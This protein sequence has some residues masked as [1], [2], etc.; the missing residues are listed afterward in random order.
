MFSEQQVEF[1]KQQ[2]QLSC[3]SNSSRSSRKNFTAKISTKFEKEWSVNV[4]TE[5]RTLSS[6]SQVRNKNSVKR[7]SSG[8][9][10]RIEDVFD[11]I[12]DALIPGKNHS[13]T[14]S[15]QGSSS[16]RS[17][18]GYVLNANRRASLS[19]VASNLAKI[20][21]NPGS[22]IKFNRQQSEGLPNSTQTLIL[23][24]FGLS[25]D[26]DE[27]G[28]ETTLKRESGSNLGSSNLQSFTDPNHMNISDEDK[29]II[30][31]KVSSIPQ[32]THV[33][34]MLI[35]ERKKNT[36]SYPSSRSRSFRSISTSNSDSKSSRSQNNL[37]DPIGILPQIEN[38]ISYPPRGLLQLIEGSS[39]SSSRIRFQE[40][41]EGDV[42]RSRTSSI[43]PD[44]NGSTYSSTHR[45]VLRNLWTNKQNSQNISSPSLTKIRMK[46]VIGENYGSCELQI[47]HPS[48]P[49]FPETSNSFFK[50]KRCYSVDT[51]LHKVE[52]LT[53]TKLRQKNVRPQFTPSMKHN[54]KVTDRVFLKVET[55]NSVSEDPTAQARINQYI[56]FEEI[57]KGAFGKV[58]KC[59]NEDSG[60]HFA[61]KILSKSRLKNKFRQ[62]R[63]ANQTNEHENIDDLRLGL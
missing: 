16:R 34:T 45:S 24:S 14:S 30:P 21:E 26:I 55:I 31:V 43:S 47:H 7:E 61:C 1:K 62:T 28:S 32:K 19:N 49:N 27:S 10:H 15:S 9:L 51:N 6:P 4:E 36:N 37:N 42:S 39:R 8:F 53:S 33:P 56:I 59:K 12:K 50:N 58:M 13:I 22:K 3:T 5:K 54:V 11:K 57:G 23:K 46:S 63:S 52:S 25:D 41:P 20:S 29:L 44:R 18:H 40:L 60:E 2:R 35:K 48:P 38:S 17:S